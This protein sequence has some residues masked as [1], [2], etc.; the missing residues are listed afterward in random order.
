MTSN[1]KPP[2]AKFKYKSLPPNAKIAIIGGGISGISTAISLQKHGYTNVKIYERDLG[3]TKKSDGYGLTISYNDSPKS[4]LVQLDILQ[5]L[6]D[7]NMKST[8]HYVFRYDGVIMGY[9]GHT[10]NST[11][12]N[13]HIHSDGHKPK[14]GNIRIQRPLLKKIMIDK[15]HP[16]TIQ[17]NKKLILL[18]CDGIDQK[19]IKVHA[20]F[21]DN[22]RE[23]F[24]L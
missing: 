16:G 9:Y 24:D 4:P 12:N 13:V 19:N 20:T 21:Q 15:L 22:T 3:N 8:S 18:E 11:K 10:D 23:Y 5:D 6:L 14:I 17:Y 7:Y 2:N 1:A